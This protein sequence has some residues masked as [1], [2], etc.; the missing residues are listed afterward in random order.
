MLVLKTTSPRASPSAPAAWPRNQVPS[1][2]AKI[3]S[4]YPPTFLHWRRGP[5]PAA[6]CRRRLASDFHVLGSARHPNA[7]A[8][9]GTPAWPQALLSFYFSSDAVTRFR[10]AAT[11]RTDDDQ[12]R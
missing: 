3:A 7:A 10:S 2:R 8:A 5:T 4:I 6:S 11:T 9:L 12:R 1:S